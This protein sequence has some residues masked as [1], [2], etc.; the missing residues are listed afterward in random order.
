MTLTFGR[1]QARSYLLGCHTSL[2]LAPRHCHIGCVCLFF[3]CLHILSVLLFV[4]LP[5]NWVWGLGFALMSLGNA[6][7]LWYFTWLG[8][9][10]PRSWSDHLAEVLPS[11][12][13]CAEPT[14]PL[15][16][17]QACMEWH[18]G[19]CEHSVSRQLVTQRWRWPDSVT[20]LC[21]QSGA[22]LSFLH[23]AAGDIQQGRRL[24][25]SPIPSLL[26][27]LSQVFQ[28]SSVKFSLPSQKWGE[29]VRQNVARRLYLLMQMH[30]MHTRHTADAHGQLCWVRG[31]G[32]WWLVS[33]AP[34]SEPMSK[35][36][37]HFRVLQQV[38]PS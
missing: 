16:G 5:L 28:F 2:I 21:L 17:S 33:I 7:Q 31:T 4:V 12:C 23:P 32:T 27:K 29:S 24:S 9:P 36:L 26:G 1:V 38:R 3:L 19:M 37:K 11:R 20:I 22:F 30:N 15:A 14:H 25:P 8:I 34:S 18:I 6:S 13:L 10:G 35:Y